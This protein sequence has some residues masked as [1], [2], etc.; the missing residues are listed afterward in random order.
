MCKYKDDD[1]N[2]HVKDLQQNIWLC[3]KKV[4]HPTNLE[5]KKES[6]WDIKSDQC[7]LTTRKS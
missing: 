7:H 6:N 3:D 5:K 4:P 2:I 1:I